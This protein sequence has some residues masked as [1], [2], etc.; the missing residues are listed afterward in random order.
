[1]YRS[2]PGDTCRYVGQGDHPR[3]MAQRPV[4]SQLAAEGEALGAGGAQLAGG[5]QQTHADGE[6]EAG[7]AFPD[8][9]GRG[10][11]VSLRMGQGGPL[12]RMAARTRSRASRTRSRASRTAASGNPTMVKPG[13]PLETWTSTETP[14]PTAPLRVAEATE[15]SMQGNGRTGDACAAWHP[16]PLCAVS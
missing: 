7:A 6:V 8:P 2:G 14:R 9:G 13:S 1:M 4:E 15:A 5:D 10:L 11:A 16:Q 3:D 12:D